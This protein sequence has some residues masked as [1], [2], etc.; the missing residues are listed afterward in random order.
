ML[1]IVMRLGIDL[2]AYFVLATQKCVTLVQ[3]RV[4]GYYAILA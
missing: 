3:I 4:T 2:L 1:R